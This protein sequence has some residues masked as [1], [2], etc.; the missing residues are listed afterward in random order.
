MSI[1][2]ALVEDNDDLRSSI[3]RLLQRSPHLRVVADYSDAESALAD[4]VR[5]EQVSSAT[6]WTTPDLL[7]WDVAG[8]LTR[9]GVTI[10]NQQLWS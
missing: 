9:L 1:R 7:A 4:L 6:L 10:P 8:M 5:M 3:K 2:V